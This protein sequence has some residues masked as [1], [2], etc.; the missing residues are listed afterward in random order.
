MKLLIADDHPIF[1]K[2][3]I[4]IL[5]PSF[6]NALIIDCENGNETL[7]KIRTE[8][9]DVCVIDI[10]M[11][12]MNGLDICKAVYA[13]KINT[14]IV[15]LTMYK[16]EE[17]YSKAFMLGASGYV[18][19]DNSVQEIVQCIK[20][21]M[22]GKK[23]MGNSH[24]HEFNK[25]LETDKKKEHIAELLKTLTQAEFKTLKLVNQSKSSREI[26]ELLFV[27]EKT[28]ENYRSRI[29]K[30]LELDSRNNS[31]LLWVMENKDLLATIR[32]F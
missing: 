21:V 11:P 8:V 14:K 2:G 29:C 7:E 15:I 23:Y 6:P 17:I 31:L 19:K 16:E 25:V 1:R 10:D 28:V 30:K 24:Q 20:T 18:I 22:I 4:E 32:E 5:R 12:E 27:S 13:E 26:S 9:P 3:L